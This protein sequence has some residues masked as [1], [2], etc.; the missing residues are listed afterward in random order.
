MIM[1][2]LYPFLYANSVTV[3]KT[4]CGSSSEG[5]DRVSVIVAPMH[6]VLL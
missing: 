5:S 4:V 6:F 1:G 3:L 2:S